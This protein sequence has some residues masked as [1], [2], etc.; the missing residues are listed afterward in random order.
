M[1]RKM[2]KNYFMKNKVIT[3]VL[4]IFL[5]F[6]AFLMALGATTFL[7]M[8]KSMNSL[9]DKAKPP[10]F[11]QMHTGEIDQEKIDTFTEK[12]S[13]VKDE[14]T[15]NMLNINSSS[16]YYE[17]HNNGKKDIISMTDNLMDNGFV[18]Q[19]EKL[20]YLLDLENNIAE[21][22]LGEIGVPV[23]YELEYNLEVG[24]TLV[25]KEG[26]YNKKFKIVTFIRDAQMGPSMAS[27]TRFLV[28]GEDFESLK[29]N[30][31]EMEYIIE[32]RFTDESYAGEFKNLYEDKKSNMP[33]NGQAITYPLIKLV[34]GFSGGMLAGMMVLVSLILI[35]IA[36]INL[37][38]SILST[39]EEEQK[40]IAMMKAI[41]FSKKDIREQYVMKYRILA[42][43]GCVVGYSFSVV[44]TPT[45]TKGIKAMFG[46]E[47][48]SVLQQLIPLLA[49][50]V[51]YF[52]VIHFCKKVIKGTEKITIVEALVYG[53]SYE[54]SRKKKKSKDEHKNKQRLCLKTIKMKNI[55]LFWALRELL[56]K[57]KSW[58]LIVIVMA[59]LTA[60]M[61]IPKNLLNTF[62]SDKFISNMGKPIC[63]LCIGINVKDQLHEKYEKVYEDIKSD[64]CVKKYSTYVTC[65]YLVKGEEGM[66]PFLVECGDYSEFPVSCLEGRMPQK[67]QEV[68][69]SYLNAN[70]LDVKVNGTI[71]VTVDGKKEYWKVT[72]I[73]QDIT[74]GGFTAKAFRKVNKEKILWYT[75]YANGNID[76]KKY[77][78]KYSF[79]KIIPMEACV[80]QTFG[81]II[82]S[83]KSG[84][85]LS[86]A[87]GISVAAL[88]VLL[89]MKLQCVKE[90]R[91]NAILKSMGFTQKEITIQ[92]VIQGGVA[93]FV[94][95][96]L[97]IVATKLIGEK[98]VGLVLAILGMEMS[99]FTFIWNIP[100]T[101]F[102]CPIILLCVSVLM[103][104]VSNKKRKKVA[105]IDLMK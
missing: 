89:F 20:D 28:N 88:M 97:G 8:Q 19:N 72:G 60:V 91:Q 65:S 82:E 68:A 35:L 52:L 101:F 67:E 66:E 41:G 6:S 48:L 80:N 38:F 59:L 63:D 15:V 27:S 18:V 96:V 32:Y 79:S 81:S 69:L 75:I 62:E 42:V 39:M 1:I 58:R 3:I 49:T 16:I 14:E 47:K 2:L 84:V 94:G 93:T 4:M 26:N 9:F 85:G 11:L 56:T 86:L 40:E 54:S 87:V 103:I 73:Y 24:D 105:I 5:I 23:S 43:I 70:N 29:N 99:E 44:F 10:H 98:I 12:V 78:Q 53:E 100:F 71:E 17:R 61:L 45:F 76:Y 74:S 57:R 33:V 77:E 13:Y 95:I 22:N 46:I 92:Y 51:V 55:N 90:Y 104:L 36:V 7:Q 31:G 21:V 102:I 64:K 37:R 25:I 50:G 34:N 30:V 83:F